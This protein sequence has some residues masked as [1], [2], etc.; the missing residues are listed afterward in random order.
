MSDKLKV[1]E[2][3]KTVL[4]LA[5]VAKLRLT[6]YYKELLTEGYSESE[7]GKFVSGNIKMEF[8]LRSI[9]LR[10]AKHEGIESEIY[11]THRTV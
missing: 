6:P 2:E 1:I 7:I 4:E 8:A 9:V 11:P 3:C 10:L 5:D